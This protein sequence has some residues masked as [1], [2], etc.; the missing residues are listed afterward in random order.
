VPRDQGD[1]QKRAASTYGYVAPEIRIG[2]RF[3]DHVEVDVGVELLL[4]AALSR[5]TWQ[6]DTKVKTSGSPTSQ[7]DGYGTFGGDTLL[8]GILV[9]ATPSLAARYAF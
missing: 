7:G 6:D 9:G 4:L 3:G 2:R 5:P 1:L 8:G